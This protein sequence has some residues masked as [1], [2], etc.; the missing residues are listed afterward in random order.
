[1]L[2]SRSVCL[3]VLITAAFFMFNM[4]AG[5]QELNPGAKEFLKGFRKARDLNDEKEVQRLVRR[6]KDEA[7]EVYDMLINTICRQETEA[8]VE[9]AGVLAEELTSSMRS[10]RYKYRLDYVLGLDQ[11]KRSERLNGWDAY[12]FGWAAYTEGAN[13][14]NPYKLDEAAGLLRKSFETFEKINDLENMLQLSLR[15]AMCY[16]ALKDGY[17]ACICFKKYR[18]ISDELPFPALDR[19]WVNSRYDYYISKG[20]DPTKPRDEGGEPA[21][22]E[23]ESEGEGEAG[24]DGGAAS[25]EKKLEKPEFKQ[26][27]NSENW[28]LKFY[29]MKKPDDFVTPAFDTGYNP[30]LWSKCLFDSSLAEISAFVP[31]GPG[32][33]QDPGNAHKWEF[34]GKQINILRNGSKFYFNIGGNE[35]TQ[36]EIKATSKPKITTLT[37][38]DRGEDNKPIK[39]SVFLQKPGQ[40]EAMFGLAMNNAPQSMDVISLRV[41]TGCYTK[42]KVSGDNIVLIDDNSNGVFGDA[43]KVPS[44]FIT[45]GNWPYWR[46]DAINIG[47]EK[48]TRPFSKYTK[49]EDKYYYLNPDRFGRK[50]TTV[51][52]SVETGYI[53]FV[54][55]GDVEPTYLVLHLL[56]ENNPGIFFNVAGF[57]DPVEVPVGEYEIACGKIEEKKK[58]KARQIRIY[59]GKAEY[60]PVVSGEETV[61]ELGAPFAFTFETGTDGDNYIVY[62]NRIN[63]WGKRNEIYAVFF[64]YVP[65]PKVSIRDKGSQRV[66]VKGD[67]MKLPDRDDYF[68]EP[69]C[70]WFPINFVYE[71]KGGM[72]L[73]TRLEAKE[74]KLLG[75]PITSEWK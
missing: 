1:M 6:N 71:N 19:E 16:E 8:L 64:D 3:S 33:T 13:N 62:G 60:I 5:A 25:G 4:F 67:K 36:E 75:G 23:G 56:D 61:L 37:G 30:Y 35:K 2:H 63:V 41:R 54:W 12:Y 49:I 29:S 17:Q 39:Y 51:E 59:H 55:N 68:N 34:Y 24:E 28:D 69:S 10:Q 40:Q 15:G 65:Q 38:E 11:E 20:Y 72:E 43:Y 74:I 22:L 70:I 52:A 58:G 50:L 66:L 73:E 53:K 9:E 48:I 47:R 18:E 46:L 44:D 32:W 7:L 26:G 31:F 14:D 21:E 57:E 45:Y 27:D 42:G